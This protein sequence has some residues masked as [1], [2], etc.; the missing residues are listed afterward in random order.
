RARALVSAADVAAQLGGDVHRS[1]RFAQEALDLYRDLGDRRG[2]ADSLIRIGGTF[3]DVGEL[4]HALPFVEE[5]RALYRQ[6]DD[7]HALLAPPR[8]LAPALQQ[9][10]GGRAAPAPPPA[11]PPP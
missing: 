3:E 7:Q 1:R 4:E 11:S 5:A 9:A 6:V 10:G 2:V 8:T